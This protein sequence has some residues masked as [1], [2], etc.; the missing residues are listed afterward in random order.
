MRADRRRVVTDDVLHD[1]GTDAGVFHPARGCVAQ[2]VKTELV[3]AAPAFAAFSLRAV[4]AFFSESASNQDV[5]KLITER[6]GP[7]RTGFR[8][9]WFVRIVARRNGFQ[10]SA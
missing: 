2:S 1:R 8:K 4:P 10:I 5:I 6:A 9:N 7:P 3:K